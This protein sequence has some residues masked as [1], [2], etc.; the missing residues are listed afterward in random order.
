MKFDFFLLVLIWIIAT[1]FAFTNYRVH[2][3]S[4]VGIFITYIVLLWI[5]FGVM[6]IVYA[7]PNYKPSLNEEVV[8]TGYKYATLGFVSLVFGAVFFYP[9]LKKIHQKITLSTASLKQTLDNSEP[10]KPEDFVPVFLLLLGV[11]ANF[12]LLPLAGRIPSLS[13]FVS[14]LASLTN[15]A[16]VLIY[17]QAATHS[18]P[19][20]IIMFGALALS[21]LSMFIILTLDGFLWF[22]TMPLVFTIV[23]SLRYLKKTW[24]TVIIL[25]IA[26]YLGMS[27]YITYISS[28]NE[29]R[30]VAWSNANLTDRV[31]NINSNIF[32]NFQLINM[33][34][35][36]LD[37]LEARLSLTHLTGTGVN[38]MRQNN[39]E[40]VYGETILNGFAMLIPRAV[41]TDKPF[42]VGGSQ[43]VTRF[44]GVRYYGSTSVGLGPFLE[45]Y[46]NFGTG[47]V[48]GGSIFI[49]L[50][51][52][53]LDDG[54]ASAV[55]SRNYVKAAFWLLPCFAL[56]IP[57]DNFITV[58]A[59]F[60]SAV[61]TIWIVM[62]GFQTLYFSS[63]WSKRHVP[64]ENSSVEVHIT[65]HEQQSVMRQ[66]PQ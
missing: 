51:L 31:G 36:N 14:Q 45:L 63:R 47:G 18:P 57:E 43:Q 6:G 24:Q 62:T 58:F 17:A 55:D 29:I 46:V 23:F 11:M 12:V 54:V 37:L 8:M 35:E 2:R 52:S 30:S 64:S 4:K 9:F 16:I 25:G 33:K 10:Q 28:R 13:A 65:I 5:T 42:V 19:K 39:Q 15:V 20:Q 22:G 7:I 27:L 3:D 48:I 32:E 56:W 44:T 61:A 1:Y 53:L 66:R 40:L 49:G 38:Y 60:G 41:W 50:I 59:K 21:V 26:S 34:D